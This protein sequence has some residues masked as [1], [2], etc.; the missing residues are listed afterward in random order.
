M[1]STQIFTVLALFAA[2][3]SSLSIAPPGANLARR[4][5]SEVHNAVLHARA[6][7]MRNMSGMAEAAEL[8]AA[9]RDAPRRVRKRGVNAR[10]CAAK[11]TSSTLPSSTVAPAV[12]VGADPT[13]SSTREAEP[14]S[15]SVKTTSE[16]KAATSAAPT[17]TKTKSKAAT[18]TSSTAKETATDDGSSSSSGSF[19]GQATFYGTGLG[20]CG[21]TNKDTDYIAAVSMLLFDGFEGYTGGN[22][23]NNPVCGKKIKANYQGKSVTITVT[24]RCVGCKMYD[25]DFAPKAFDQLADEALGR[26]SG[27]TWSWA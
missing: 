7:R 24:D 3:A 9:K 14:T 22:P 26:L 17:T 10:R 8:A 13:T 2:S 21:I 27:M 20:A 4:H 18:K 16:A 15:T 5:G 6:A 12:N 19:T 25:L 23:N 11:T 1:R